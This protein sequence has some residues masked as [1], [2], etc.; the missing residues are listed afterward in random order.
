MHDIEILLFLLT[1]VVALVAGANRLN[2]PYP[3]LLVVGGLCL[4]FV[5][6]LPVLKFT[7]D[8]IFLLFLPP[9]LHS[10]A[11][12][13]SWRDFQRNW[14]PIGLLAIGL[15]LFTTIGIA[16]V[17][18]R[19]IPG[20]PLAVAFVLGAIAAPTDAV[21][22]SA[23]G[24]RLRLPRRILVVLSGESLLNDA[25]ALVIYRAAVAAVVSG[26]FSIG[27]AATHFVLASLGGVVIGLALG[28][29]L[30]YVLL[31]TKDTTLA[32]TISL[33]CPYIAYLTAERL[34]VSGV[35]ATVATG[36]YLGRQ[37]NRIFTPQQ[38]LQSLGFWQV[39]VFLLNGLLFILVGLQLH[40]ILR[41]LSM[42]HWPT[43]L[44]YA[45]VASLTV[46]LTRVVWV[47]LTTYLPPMFSPCKPLRE[48][49]P[50]WQNIAVVAWSGARGGVSLASALAVPAVI[51]SGAPFPQ[52]DMVLFLTFSIIVSTLVLQGLTLPPLI[53]HL[54]VKDDGRT[55]K[56]ERHAR[57]S[58]TE[59]AIHHLEA[60][61]EASG[62]SSEAIEDLRSHYQERL[63][64]LN[65][66][67]D[68]EEHQRLAEH[69]QR[70]RQLKHSLLASERDAIVRLRDEGVISD[71]ALHRVQRDLDLEEIRLEPPQHDS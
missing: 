62:V 46:I 58:A 7:P 29:V 11:W 2:I 52:H 47:T 67:E 22:V 44:I 43:L 66:W 39:L 42:R 59:G 1:A 34:H 32:S 65:S 14:K 61:A 55:E 60:V 57:L 41:N 12:F 49:T 27:E 24:E 54:H 17:M 36:L 21:A 64:H 51:Q 23:V 31:R 30:A 20:M 15:V 35:L 9:L 53:R 16:V 71:D 18:D 69:K 6:N 25:S 26:T 38:R 5:P 40:S 8:L 70:Y 50:P 37:A 33:L 4:S 10:E 19:L 56:E 13:T 3:I 48:R 45:C 28:Y 68:A 63:R